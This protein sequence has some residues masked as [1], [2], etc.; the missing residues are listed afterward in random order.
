VDNSPVR[1]GAPCGCEQRFVFLAG[2]GQYFTEDF[3]RPVRFRRFPRDRIHR[4]YDCGMPVPWLAGKPL[5]CVAMH[6]FDATC[7]SCSDIAVRTGH[8]PLKRGGE[9]RCEARFTLNGGNVKAARG[10]LKRI[11]TEPGSNV[12]HTCAATF[13]PP[14]HRAQEE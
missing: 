8:G 5:S 13:M 2:Y 3:Q 10:E 14:E 11:P 4:I 6:E 1:H 9:E 12:Q 7:V